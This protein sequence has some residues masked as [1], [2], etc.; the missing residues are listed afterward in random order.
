V[1]E[2]ARD[3]AAAEDSAETSLAHLRMASTLG[4]RRW[5][6]STFIGIALLIIVG[7]IFIFPILWAA[8]CSL[9]STNDILRHRYPLSWSS[10][11]PLRPTFENYVTLFTTLNFQKNLL[12]TLIAGAAQVV[13]AV[14]TSSLAGY[15]FARLRFPGRDV[16]FAILLLT[17]FIQVE[18][19][20]V[21]LYEVVSW[22][23]LASTYFAL[24]L[25]FA[26]S[27]FGIYLMRQSFREI[28]I[29]LEEAARIDGAGPIR[30]FFRIA[31][32][33]V[34]PALATLVLI[35]FIWSWNAYLWPL[36]IM[37]DTEKQIAQVAIA[38]LKSIPNF[39]QDGPLF[40]AASAVTIPLVVLAMVLQRYY[41][42]G[43]VTSGFR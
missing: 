39:S 18:S 29:E 23:G 2:L 1:S 42:R 33:N 28:P 13:L 10:V 38:S 31:L 16:L 30:I 25:P 17:A 9:M 5:G 12:N 4:R 15:A 43:L 8:M 6:L 14:V 20:L 37:Q 24:F 22:M 40:A 35:Q 11:L 19:M 34:L 41:V 26:C 32:P 27:P 36:V 3:F 21:P 7:F